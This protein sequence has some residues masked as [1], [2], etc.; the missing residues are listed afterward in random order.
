MAHED[1]AGVPVIQ[2]GNVMRQ[3]VQREEEFSNEA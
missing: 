1:C 3:Q 2:R